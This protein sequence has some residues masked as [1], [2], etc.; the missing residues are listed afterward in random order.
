MPRL[1]E[2]RN[3]HVAVEGK[4][5]IKGLNL[6]IKTGEIHAVMGP[7]GSGKST[8]AQ[9]IMGHP[10]YTVTSGHINLSGRRLTEIKPDARA[11]RGLFL[12]WQYPPAVPGLQVEQFLRSARN[13]QAKIRGE[14]ILS[15]KDFR[16]V[17]EKNIKILRFREDLLQRSLNDGFSGGEKK[18]FEILQ[19]M[20]L[21]PRLAILD[22]TD[23]GL[24]L[25]ALKTVMEALKKIAATTSIMVI[26]HYP[27]LL[28]YFKPHQVHIMTGGKIVASG[29]SKLARRVERSGYRN[30]VEAHG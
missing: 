20:V 30:F 19:L 6:K 28:R 8:L 29:D 21:K 24:D 17:L 10:A 9:V 18:R 15:A 11:A 1:L 13:A 14:P 12:A 7:N 22:E 26:T 5:I 16:P 3:L 4:E 2:I 25:D 27:R 23:S